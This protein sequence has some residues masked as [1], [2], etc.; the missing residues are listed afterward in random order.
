MLATSLDGRL[1][2]PHGGAAQLGGPGDRRVL[3]EALAWADAALLGAETLR[4]HGTTC[5]IRAVDLLEQRRSQGRADQPVALVLSRSGLLPAGLP[6]WHQP[7][8]RWWLRPADQPPPEPAMADRFDRLVPFSDW[9]VLLVD[10]ASVGLKRLVLLGGADLTGQLLATGLVDE[11]QLTLCPM[12]LGGSHAWCAD[13]VRPAPDRWQLLEHR[14]LGGGE[15]LLRYG[16]VVSDRCAHHDQK[17]L[18]A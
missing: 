7:L 8:E 5:Q 4:R 9:G 16:R 6:F 2:P 3:E 13:G 18:T 15:L 1:A 10:L 14:P 17:S 12:L 11:L